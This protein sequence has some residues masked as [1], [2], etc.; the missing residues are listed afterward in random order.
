MRKTLLSAAALV[1]LAACGGNDETASPD[2]EVGDIDAADQVPTCADYCTTIEAACAAPRDQWSNEATC[3]GACAAWSVGTIDDMSGNTLGCRNYH[4][5]A[6][7]GDPATHCVHAGPGGAGA[8]GTNCEGFCT[9]ALDACTGANEQWATMGEC[10]TECAGYDTAEAYDITD[11]GGDSFACRLYHLT[12][13]V[14]DP[15]THCA[16]I[17][18]ASA[19]CN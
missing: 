4:A 7:E 17:V 9:L 18:D 16:H 1:L 11:T 14:G 8:C 5:G 10:M 6:A 12:A 19:T 2:A 15:D 13:A 3:L